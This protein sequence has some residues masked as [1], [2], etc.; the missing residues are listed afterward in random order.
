[1]TLRKWKSCFH[2]CHTSLFASN[3]ATLCV[4]YPDKLYLNLL[5][6]AKLKMHE[7]PECM[8][9][10]IASLATCLP[11]PL[12]TLT[13]DSLA[14]ASYQR[15][16]SHRHPHNNSKQS[17]GTN[18]EVHTNQLALQLHHSP[19]PLQACMQPPTPARQVLIGHPPQQRK[20]RGSGVCRHLIS[21]GP[22]SMCNSC[23]LHH[24]HDE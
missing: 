4:Q 5:A 18:K 11:A 3:T 6:C 1:M 8:S 13:S 10:P 12:I 19:L 15:T 16:E 14:L 23:T 20:Q 7:K 22:P 9:Y 2:D 21:P 24:S 17:R